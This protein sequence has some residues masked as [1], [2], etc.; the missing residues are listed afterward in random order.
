MS[1]DLWVKQEC[2]SI[3]FYQNQVDDQ[4]TF[5]IGLQTHWIREMMVK[6]SHNILIFMESTFS[7]NK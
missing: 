6:L 4:I 3:F 7:T 2:Q 5:I 1:I